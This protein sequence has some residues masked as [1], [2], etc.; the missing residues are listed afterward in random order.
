MALDPIYFSALDLGGG[1][2]VQFSHFDGRK[3]LRAC[4]FVLIEEATADKLA[5]ILALNNEF[6]IQSLWHCSSTFRQ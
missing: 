1:D 2:F 6:L 4:L 5:T 3:V